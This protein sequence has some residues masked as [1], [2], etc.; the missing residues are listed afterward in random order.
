MKSKRSVN[1]PHHH[2]I[3][4]DLPLQLQQSDPSMNPFALPG[5]GN[6]LKTGGPTSWVAWRLTKVIAIMKKYIII[7]LAKR[8]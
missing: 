2:S 5:V 1:E 4:T 7:G 3:D 6:L 8:N